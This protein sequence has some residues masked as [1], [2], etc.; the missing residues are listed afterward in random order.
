M[1]E[2]TAELEQEMQQLFTELIPDETTLT[3]D[4]LIQA[5][6]HILKKDF[7]VQSETGTRRYLQTVR[8][9]REQRV[10]VPVTLH[11]QIA[12]NGVVDYI[13]IHAPR[14]IIERKKDSLT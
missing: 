3:Q 7:Q 6:D 13:R 5:A 14:F 12:E 8:V 11:Y 4:T 1:F 2:T 9:V 10:W